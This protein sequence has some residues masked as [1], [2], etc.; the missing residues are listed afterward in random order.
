MEA[1]VRDARP[2]GLY[3]AVVRWLKGVIASDYFAP[4]AQMNFTREGVD[5][6]FLPDFR[7]AASP[8]VLLV[9]VGPGVF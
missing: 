3:E 1:S 7:A 2:T 4:M 5:Q 8:P 9:H 6:A